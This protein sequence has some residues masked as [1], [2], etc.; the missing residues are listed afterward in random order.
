MIC[1]SEIVQRD[2]SICSVFVVLL[3]FSCFFIVICSALLILNFL[4]WIIV[5]QNVSPRPWVPSLGGLAAKGRCQNSKLPKKC[6]ISAD[7][8]ASQHISN[9]SVGVG[10]VWTRQ[11]SVSNAA[12]GAL[13]AGYEK[14]HLEIP[15]LGKLVWLFWRPKLMEQTRTNKPRKIGS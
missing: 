14:N 7:R 10:S 1:M 3:V 15:I 13:G 11:A 2:L 5:P 4:Q 12:A 6:F 9:K 8:Q